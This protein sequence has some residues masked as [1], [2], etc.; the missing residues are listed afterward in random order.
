MP[1]L[2][3]IVL[4]SV[5]RGIQSVPEMLPL[6]RGWGVAHS[7]NWTPHLSYDTLVILKYLNYQ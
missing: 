2:I 1:P 3:L 7:F 4:S 6:K 5:D